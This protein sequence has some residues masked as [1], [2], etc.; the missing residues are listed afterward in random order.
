MYSLCRQ[1]CEDR[2]FVYR[3]SVLM[4]C[5]LTIDEMVSPAELLRALDPVYRERE[6][7]LIVR[8]Y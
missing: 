5:V 8:V 6:Y 1:M 3:E 7:L 2:V 4:E